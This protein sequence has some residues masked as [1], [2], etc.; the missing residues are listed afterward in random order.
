[1]DLLI[2]RNLFSASYSTGLRRDS[3][4]EDAPTGH[5][6][7]VCLVFLLFPRWL[8]QVRRTNIYYSL[9]VCVTYS[10]SQLLDINFSTVRVDAVLAVLNTHRLFSFD[11]HAA[12]WI[13]IDCLFCLMVRRRGVFLSFLQ[14]TMNLSGVAVIA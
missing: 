11:S 4:P 2:S 12:L 13:F 8:N 3:E 5:S 1:M 9:G 6:D 10:L 7:S 14:L